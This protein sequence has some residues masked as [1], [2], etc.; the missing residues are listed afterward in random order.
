MKIEFSWLPRVKNE[1]EESM[2]RKFTRSVDSVV[3]ALKLILNTQELFTRHSSIKHS[4]E[5]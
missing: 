2:K 5:H 3:E 4:H 1:S